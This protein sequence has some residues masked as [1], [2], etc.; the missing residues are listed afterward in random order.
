MQAVLAT[1]VPVN[2]L[3]LL[4]LKLGNQLAQAPRGRVLLSEAPAAFDSHQP[5]L[6]N[7]PGVV[8][9]SPL[10]AD[11]RLVALW[12]ALAEVSSYP[13]TLCR[14]SF[15]VDMVARWPAMSATRK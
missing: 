4:V 12:N 2:E 1:A 3:G 7:V 6:V 10:L 9:E 13:R 15:V 11:R 14:S 8:A 5:G